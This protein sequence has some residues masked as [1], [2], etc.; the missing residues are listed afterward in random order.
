MKCNSSFKNSYKL[1]QH[2]RQK[3]DEKF[4]CLGCNKQLEWEGDGMVALCSKTY[5]GFCKASDN[6]EHNVKLSC[7]GLNKAINSKDMNSGIF[8][9][10]VN[11]QKATGG[12]NRSFRV[13][14]KDVF[15]YSQKKKA[16]SYLYI[17]RK[18]HADRIT[19]SP[20]D[21]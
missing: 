8:L 6:T 10:V 11:N 17:K 12:T 20:L 21:I 3:D 7:K 9:S 18:V 4:S 16:L 19:T 13:V 15:M 2:N 1:A 14:G 5:Y